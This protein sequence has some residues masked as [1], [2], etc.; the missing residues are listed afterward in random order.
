MLLAIAHLIFPQYFKWKE[1][2]QNLSLINKQM[3]ITH[4]FFIALTVFM[5]GLLCVTNTEDLIS[6]DLGKA[7]CLGLAIFWTIRLFIQFF[8]YSSKLWRGKLFE[9]A[10]HFVF[11]LFWLYS[12]TIFWIVFFKN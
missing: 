8:G 7:I 4:T 5:M 10:V 1:E 9:T 11:S 2:L 3:M 6:S 12:S